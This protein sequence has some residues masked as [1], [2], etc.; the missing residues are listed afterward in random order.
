MAKEKGQKTRPKNGAKMGIMG[1]VHLMLTPEKIRKVLSGEQTT[2][3]LGSARELYLQVES[4]PQD[5][6]IEL[7]PWFDPDSTEIT[8]ENDFQKDGGDGNN[9]YM[10]DA[11]EFTLVE[12]EN[13]SLGFCV[14]AEQAKALAKAL[15]SY[16]QAWDACTALGAE[17][18]PV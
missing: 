18:S 9:R 4:G 17:Q 16:A 7:T 12:S 14:T 3:E 6:I 1:T 13:S 10:R 15:M 8:I 2:I 5:R 11:I